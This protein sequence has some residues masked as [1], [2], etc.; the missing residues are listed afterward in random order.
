[1]TYIN[2]GLLSG[3]HLTTLLIICVIKPDTINDKANHIKR[4]VQVANGNPL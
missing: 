1:M 2:G 4:K 3:L